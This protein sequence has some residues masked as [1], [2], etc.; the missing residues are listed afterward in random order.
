MG[1]RFA[2]EHAT[3]GKPVLEVQVAKSTSNPKSQ[4]A[5]NAEPRYRILTLDGGGIR[6]V[7]TAYW[8][9][10]LEKLLGGPVA[11]HVDL[12]AGTSTGSILASAL[13]KRIPAREII[14]LYREKGREI[15]P[16]T[17]ER[18]WN[19][20]G[21]LFSQGP[22]APK[23]GGEGLQDAL[24][25]CLGNTLMSELEDHPKLLITAYNTVI[26]EPVIFKSWREEYTFVPL[27][28]AAKASSSAPTYFPAH[29]TGV[30]GAETAL[31]DGG[32]VA[33][34]PTACAIAEGVKLNAIKDGCPM[35]RFIVGSFG[36]GE[37]TRPIGVSQ[38]K[39]WGA[40][41]WAVPI[42]SVLMDG[43]ADSVSYIARQLLAEEHYYRFDT[44]LDKAFDDM[45]DASRTNIEALL[46][47]AQAYLSSDGQKK[48]AR[49]AKHLK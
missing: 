9:S 32:V 12:I 27:W 2:P 10:E 17:G 6:G 43:A 36:T 8:L 24:K 11:E 19:R 23:Y 26:R 46:N 5:G 49:F 48:L 29:I 25:E 1:A 15:F 45:D 16:S 41:E 7:M 28:E 31:V 20:M 4:S 14:E 3:V 39:E 44:K 30:L 22:S 21:R 13:C 40:L 34:N 38:A 42:I 35:N 33:N 18:L 47:V 37:S